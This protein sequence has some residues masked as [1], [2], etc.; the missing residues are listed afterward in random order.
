MRTESR[1]RRKD[2]TYIWV[3]SIT[4]NH[5]DDPTIRGIVT[6]YRDITSR[7][8]AEQAVRASEARCSSTRS[9]T[10]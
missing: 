1:T 7:K 6:H 3:D 4:T 2:G 5:L 8:E 10:C 9:R